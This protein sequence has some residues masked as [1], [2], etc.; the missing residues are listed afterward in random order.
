[1]IPMFW[2]KKA[3][4]KPPPTATPKQDLDSL[5]PVARHNHIAYVP[6]PSWSGVPGVG[7]ANLVYAPDVLL[8]AP[9]YYAGNALPVPANQFNTVK[10]PAFVVA[11]KTV[12]E[13][14]GGVQ[15]GQIAYQQL[16]EVNVNLGN[17]TPE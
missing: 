3:E 15:A 14:I 11:P 12:L 13:G 7:T 17:T 5:G 9:V 16:L 8:S 6:S 10:R 1:M 4:V 2:R